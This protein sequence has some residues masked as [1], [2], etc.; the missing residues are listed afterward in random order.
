M[1]RYAVRH[2]RCFGD[3]GMKVLEI[4]ALNCTVHVP[5]H[6]EKSTY[7]TV[8]S[9]IFLHEMLALV[10]HQ[11]QTNRRQIQEALKIFFS[12]VHLFLGTAHEFVQV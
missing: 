5:V 12:A 6:T 8:H 4:T 3:I 2:V 7:C 1:Y 10:T 9:Y 11:T